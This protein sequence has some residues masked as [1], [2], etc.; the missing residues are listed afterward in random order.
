MGAIVMKQDRPISANPVLAPVEREKAAVAAGD[1]A[2]YFAILTE[3]AIFMPPQSLAKSGEELRSWLSAFLRDFQI[4]W[5]SFASTELEVVESLAYHTFT[6]TWLATPRAGGEGKVASGKGLHIL[7]RQ[8]DGSW[9]IAR[10]IWNAV[11][12]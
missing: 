7:R 6:Y 10:E 2:A 12:S 9:K 1:P 11:P 5:L 3:D 4:E 8:T